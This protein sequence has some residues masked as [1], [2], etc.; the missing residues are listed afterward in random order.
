MAQYN[1]YFTSDA[2]PTKHKIETANFLKAAER[3]FNLLQKIHPLNDISISPINVQF[4]NLDINMECSKFSELVPISEK[5]LLGFKEAA[6]MLSM[7]EQASRDLVHEGEGQ[8]HSNEENKF[9]LPMK[10]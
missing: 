7:T 5:L 2:R 6:S 9:V 8:L 1:S 3:I 10:D 4:S